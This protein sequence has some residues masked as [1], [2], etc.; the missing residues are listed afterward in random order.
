MDN[1]EG[2]LFPLPASR[3]QSEEEEI[4]IMGCAVGI[5]WKFPP[6]NK[7]RRWNWL[8]SQVV[9]IVMV[10]HLLLQ[11]KAKTDTEDYA[12]ALSTNGKQKSLNVC[13]AKS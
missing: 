13:S 7:T 4:L 8:M 3:R 1:T 11:M 6:H 2:P 12:M 5:H 9:K 10:A